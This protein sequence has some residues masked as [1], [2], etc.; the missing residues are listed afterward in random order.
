L[1]KY[2][3]LAPQIQPGDLAQIARN[4]DFLGVNYYF[5]T[6]IG[7]DER[8]PG[9]E[10]TEM[11]WEVHAPALERLLLRLN[12]DYKLPP[13]FITEN[14]AAFQDEVRADG[15][16]GD[17]RRTHYLHT[18]L[19]AVA[20]AIGQGVDVRGY[21]AWSLLDNFEWAYGYSKRFGI[22][23]VDY[24]TQR[25]ALKDSAKWYAQ[26]IAKNVL[27]ASSTMAG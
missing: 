18:H 21:F 3:P 10:Y 19:S 26:T 5:R 4:L 22:V 11:G 20:R 23:Y 6:V 27:A 14:G 16:I 13:I 8:A 24:K 9:S 25:R 7:A 2:G 1:E 12:A 15:S 17:A